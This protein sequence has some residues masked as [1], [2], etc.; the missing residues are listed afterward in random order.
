M[1]GVILNLAAWFTL[2]VLFHRID[3][4]HFG[5]LRWFAVDVTSLDVFAA[6]LTA[7]AAVLVFGLHRG[8]IQTVGIMA[9]LGIVARY[10]FGA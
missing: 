5:P 1:V 10:M 2:H 8:L 4:R 3:E 7:I 6:V 9:A